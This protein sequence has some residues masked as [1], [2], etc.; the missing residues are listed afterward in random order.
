MKERILRCRLS[1]QLVNIIQYQH[2]NQLI[3][4]QEIIDLVLTHGFRELRLEHVRGHV[5]HHLVRVILLHSI[6]IAWAK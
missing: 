2:V 5:Q 1:R 4:M 6:P 3:E